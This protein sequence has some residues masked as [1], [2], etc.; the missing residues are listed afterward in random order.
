MFKHQTLT[1]KEQYKKIDQLSLDGEILDLGGDIRSGYLET[2]GGDH[3][4]TIL[5]QT[6]ESGA[7]IR[8][9]LEKPLPIEEEKF[10]HV[11]AFNLLEH[12][13][14]FSQLSKEV[15]RVLKKDGTFI[16]TVPYLFP[17]HYSP[18]D[19]FRY[20]NMALEKLLKDVSGFKSVDIKPLGSGV[21][22]ACSVLVD[23][24]TPR[25]LRI[26][27]LISRPLISIADLLCAWLAKILG[28]SY[29]AEHY[30]LGYFVVAK[31]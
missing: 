30:P 22:S 5:N 31:K 21:F 17:I 7:H 13:Y 23:R 10:D 14:N 15:H 6:E 9:D 19:Y 29:R 24:V 16:I 28:K 8:H 20:T 18:K 26:I 11:L 3:N 2:I 25:P 27:L 4:F 12:I 1:R